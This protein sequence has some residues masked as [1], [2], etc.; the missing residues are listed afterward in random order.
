[1]K[2]PTPTRLTLTRFAAW[3]ALI[4]LACASALASDL[5]TDLRSLSSRVAA[6]N[7][8]TAGALVPEADE[9][10][11]DIRREIGVAQH[12][13]DATV[14]QYRKSFNLL[15]RG[16][17]GRAYAYRREK[18]GPAQRRVR[19]LQ[20]LEKQ[21]AE[22]ASQARAM[23]A[24][25]EWRQGPYSGVAVVGVYNPALKRVEWRQG[26]YSGIR[27]AGAYNPRT[28]QVEWKQGPYSGIGVAGVYNPSKGVVEWQQGRYSGI[29]V[30]GAYNPATGQ[31]EFRQ[32]RYSEMGIAGVYNP[33]TRQ[34]EWREGRYSELAVHGVYNAATQRVE[35]RDGRYSGLATFGVRDPK[36]GAVEWRDGPY[37]GLCVYGVA[38]SDEVP[39][40][41]STSG[42]CPFEDDDD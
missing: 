20:A 31:V 35:W 6:S 42:G 24:P 5:A 28:Q 23:A 21:A 22:V 37:S 30:A 16:F 2:S 7:Y 29:N 41:F 26:P 13:L 18:I 8:E 11:R 15:Q 17:D 34:I 4:Q 33:A 14:E 40:E 38:K 32:G 19:G 12:D 36:S 9:L 25:V 3:A 1:M 10:R 39:T 27:L